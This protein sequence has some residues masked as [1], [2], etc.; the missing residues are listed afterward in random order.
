M[1]D[2]VTQPNDAVSLPNDDEAGNIILEDLLDP[3][4]DAIINDVE[5]E[6]SSDADDPS[7]DEASTPP[8]HGPTLISPNIQS[9]VQSGRTSLTPSFD[10]NPIEAMI[11]PSVNKHPTNAPH[12]TVRSTS[13]RALDP[14]IFD[15]DSSLD[16]PSP[17]LKTP[18]SKQKPK[19]TRPIDPSK[20]LTKGDCFNILAKANKD[21][22]TFVPRH[23]FSFLIW[24]ITIIHFEYDPHMIRDPTQDLDWFVELYLTRTPR[25]LHG[26][27]YFVEWF[28]T[29]ADLDGIKSFHERTNMRFVA[30]P[31]SPIFVLLL[32]LAKFLELYQLELPRCDSFAEFLSNYAQSGTF[33]SNKKPSWPVYYMSHHLTY[34]SLWNDS[35][36]FFS[37]THPTE[38]I[39]NTSSIFVGVRG[40]DSINNSIKHSKPDSIRYEVLHGN[41]PA[42]TPSNTDLHH[43]NN[44]VTPYAQSI[45]RRSTKTGDEDFHNSFRVSDIHDVPPKPQSPHS[46]ERYED[47]FEGP[48]TKLLNRQI[49]HDNLKV[50]NSKHPIRRDVLHGTIPHGLGLR[51][52]DA[53]V[54]TVP[55]TFDPEEVEQCSQSILH[56][57]RHQVG[58]STT[59]FTNP[60]SSITSL[61]T[62]DNQH[63]RHYSTGTAP[64][65][66][67]TLRNLETR[68]QNELTSNQKLTRKLDY[69]LKWDRDTP[70]KS[71]KA[72]V[73]H[74]SQL[75]GMGY[76]VTNTFMHDYYHMHTND[77]SR[78]I[79]NRTNPSRLKAFLKYYERILTCTRD[80]RIGM[81]QLQHDNS[82]FYGLLGRACANDTNARLIIAKANSDGILAFRELIRRLDHQGS[83]DLYFQH[84]IRSTYESLTNSQNLSTYLIRLEEI[85]HELQDTPH[86]VSEK[87]RYQRLCHALTSLDDLTTHVAILKT[88]FAQTCDP[89]TK[90]L[91]YLRKNINDRS[92]ANL[93]TSQQRCNSATHSV[94]GHDPS[95]GTAQRAS[96]SATL[97]DLDD[98]DIA[99]Y[100]RFISDIN[101]RQ[102]GPEYQIPRH[103][104]FALPKAIRRLLLKSRD[105]LPQNG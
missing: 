94:H 23:F 85:Y 75:A 92:F 47:P 104:F 91:E 64:D 65:D 8:N 52:E 67:I 76:L 28:S 44:H 80:T 60:T 43:S 54:R 66:A 72:A 55:V 95:D 68:F 81:A 105:T 48:K 34:T 53:G 36:R 73:I 69:H 12:V 14:S 15:H 2:Y 96:T 59:I 7:L 1:S 102:L 61:L 49:L 39:T 35:V 9:D 11:N 100:V 29:S 4:H 38:T 79:T 83:K 62:E 22:S 17:V 99:D 27:G 42:F 19:H 10:H 101:R 24:S 57:H 3:N 56:R 84:L 25:I 86:C 5:V 88:S 33:R 89:F 26:L 74:T 98:D 45:G 30:H 103:L 70:F 71:F 32:L 20:P 41:R 90:S 58:T 77:P 51:L 40:G 46:Q 21:I 78:S 37:Q 97:Q 18:L 87:D 13:Q 6:T 93:L 50:Y 16:D 31:H 82:L 63:A